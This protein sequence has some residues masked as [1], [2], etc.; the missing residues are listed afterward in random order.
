[1][2][3]FTVII[4]LSARLWETAISSNGR[5]LPDTSRSVSGCD[6]EGVPAENRPVVGFHQPELQG[7]SG[8]FWVLG[9]LRGVD[10]GRMEFVV[11]PIRMPDRIDNVL[12]WFAIAL[13]HPQAPSGERSVRLMSSCAR[14]HARLRLRPEWR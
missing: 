8:P 2:C 9:I 1:M 5:E 12:L 10:A 4:A 13:Y 7:L 14:E 6:I 3:V 11:P